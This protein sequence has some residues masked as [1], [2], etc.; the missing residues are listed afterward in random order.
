MKGINAYYSTHKNTLK[1]SKDLC[2]ASLICRTLLVHW[3]TD[4]NL[5]LYNKIATAS[6]PTRGFVLVEVGKVRKIA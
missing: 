6:P 3:L 5:L 1:L 4:K 2:E